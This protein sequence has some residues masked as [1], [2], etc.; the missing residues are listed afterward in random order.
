MKTALF[1]FIILAFV[2]CAYSFQQHAPQLLNQIKNLGWLGPLFFLLFYCL[3]TVF[4]LP[5]MVLTL[6]GGALFGP[7]LGTVLNLAGAT[8]GA[9]AAFCFSRYLAHD[10]FAAKS[11]TRLNNLILGVEKRGWQFVALLRLVPIVPFSLVNYGLGI[12]GIKFSH[13]VITTLIFLAPA[14]LV[15]TYCGYAGMGA[16]INPQSFHNYFAILLTV[17]GGFI[18]L[19]ILKIKLAYRRSN[20]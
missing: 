11:G 10:W 3:A 8:L 19:W 2:I 4:L 18:V 15:Y 17:L 20:R 14:E 13:Y 6:A 7:F 12:T 16:I 9:A 5:T 1:V